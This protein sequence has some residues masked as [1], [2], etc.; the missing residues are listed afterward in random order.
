MYDKV[1]KVN[2]ISTLRQIF[3]LVCKAAPKQVAVNAVLLLLYS[4]YGAAI[5]YCTNS[6]FDS[7]RYAPCINIEITKALIIFIAV[8][9][10]KELISASSDYISKWICEICLTDFSKLLHK[11]ASSA[12]PLCFED[13]RY[14]DSIQ[15]A[16][17]GVYTIPFF[18][19]NIMGLLFYD[20]PYLLIMDIY[21][22]KIKPVLFVIPLCV[23]VPVVL[24]QFLETYQQI[25][26]KDEKTPL[27]RRKESYRSYMC[28]LPFLKE[29]RH[30]GCFKYFYTLYIYVNEVLIKKKIKNENKVLR[31]RVINDLMSLCGFVVAVVCLYVFT[32][33][34]SIPISVFASVFYALNSL[35]I[36]MERII[37]ERLSS[38]IV[39]DYSSINGFLRYMEM[40]DQEFGKCQNEKMDMISLKNVS[41]SYPG[42]DEYAVRNISL[43][44]KKNQRIAIV[45][46]NGSGK[47]TLTKLILGIYKPTSGEIYVNGVNTLE[48]AKDVIYKHKTAVFQDFYKYLFSLGENIAISQ[49]D[50]EWE[51]DR[52]LQSVEN[53][54]LTMNNSVFPDGLQ[55]VLSQKFGGIDLSGGEWQRV[56][57][58]RGNY[59]EHEL[60]ILDEPTAMIDPLQEEVMYRELLDSG[61][62]SI[63]VVITH[64]MA[65]VKDVDK[66]LFMQAGEIVQEGTHHELMETN[67]SYRALFTS[68]A[69]WYC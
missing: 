16:E 37:S 46:V 52:L 3:S 34:G 58:A 43:E 67:K 41:F 65:V 50:R 35:Q 19:I 44:L 45:G 61:N 15:K 25:K 1:K 63:T 11:K 22:I 18:V 31:I 30:L 28:D 59:R 13:A 12:E 38:I 54:G 56:A 7:I 69:Q 4:G 8:V 40:P 62:D 39:N 23:F 51:E 29:T 48:L 57:L 2:I 66:V 6:L 33:N 55:T 17:E 9:T 36:N 53:V 47:T 68:Q 60:I 32:V 20:I 26:Y 10:I 64:R 5:V 14:L 42:R 24:S 27:E 21:L 49:C